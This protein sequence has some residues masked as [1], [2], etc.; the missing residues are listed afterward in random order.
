MFV[1][2][3]LGADYGYRAAASA[4]DKAARVVGVLNN[5]IERYYDVD[6]KGNFTLK[7][8]E[9]DAIY[10]KA[11]DP[12]ARKLA[13][14]K[15]ELLK[16]LQALS[17]AASEYGLLNRSYLLDAMGLEEGGRKRSP[18]DLLVAGS[19][20]MFN[21]SE[22]YIRQVTL[23]GSYKL[24]LDRLRKTIPVQPIKNL[25]RRPWNAQSC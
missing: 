19:A 24:E 4:M 18:F 6:D 1:Y 15:V 8:S 10:N 22:R 11:T 21:H 23:V 2:P 16:D 14:E 5:D 3:Y 7:Q 20:F 12:E 9:V 25:K 13:D 17:Q